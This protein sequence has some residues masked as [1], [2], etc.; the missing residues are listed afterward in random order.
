M[1]ERV[2]VR[3]IEIRA[4]QIAKTGLDIAQRLVIIPAI[5]PDPISPSPVNIVLSIAL[6]KQI[7]GQISVMEGQ[8]EAAADPA[9]QSRIWQPGRTG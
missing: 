2:E 4:Q 9:Q 1:G 7:A 8:A 3:P 5:N 6:V